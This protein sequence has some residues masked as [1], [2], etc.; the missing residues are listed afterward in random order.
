MNLNLLDL[1]ENPAFTQI[2][3]WEDVSAPEGGFGLSNHLSWFEVSAPPQPLHLGGAT[4]L[5][6]ESRLLSLLPGRISL[7]QI[8]FCS[9]NFRC[10]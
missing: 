2:R 9:G 3:F 8:L 6:S 10:G 5:T 4:D 7:L 1:E